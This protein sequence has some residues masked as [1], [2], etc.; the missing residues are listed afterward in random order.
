[1]VFVTCLLT[2]ILCPGRLVIVT[3]IAAT[4]QSLPL[5]QFTTFC[6]P[7]TYRKHW[8]KK[9]HL[10]NHALYRDSV[11]F[12]C[13]GHSS[14]HEKGNFFQI[15]KIYSVNKKTNYTENIKLL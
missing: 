9:G 5:Y 3:L 14:A 13:G 12:S 15:E 6:W 2:I 4:F 8:E 1:M 7:W 11:C 10:Q